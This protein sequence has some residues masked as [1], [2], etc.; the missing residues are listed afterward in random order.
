M[1]NVF[2]N[3]LCENNAQ[4]QKPF[5]Y[6]KIRKN[7]TGTS[8]VGAISKAQGKSKEDPLETKKF[9]K[10]VAQYRKKTKRGTVAGG[11]LRW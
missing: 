2:R 3:F 6:F 4:D 11:R 5:G 9:S 7:M 10:K 8:Q 1:E